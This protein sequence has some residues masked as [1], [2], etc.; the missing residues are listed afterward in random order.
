MTNATHLTPAN[1]SEA[2]QLSLVRDFDA[3][4]ALATGEERARLE[5]AADYA[6]SSA[7]VKAWEKRN[8]VRA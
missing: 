4:A 8:G 3:R 6:R 7:P 5:R 2:F 1:K